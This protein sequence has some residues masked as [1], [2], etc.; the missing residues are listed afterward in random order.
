MG[1]AKE[2]MMK[3]EDDR[4]WALTVLH[5][6]GVLEC[7]EFHGEYSQGTNEV[8]DAYRLANRKITAG[9]APFDDNERRDATDTIKSAFEAHN[10]VDGCRSCE[11]LFAED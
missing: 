4:R 9:V 11:K 5:E 10:F 1:A 6:A 8:E 7:C 3:A 2:A